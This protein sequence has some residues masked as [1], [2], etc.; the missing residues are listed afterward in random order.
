MSKLILIL[1]HEDDTDIGRRLRIFFIPMKHRF[2]TRTPEDVLSGDVKNALLAF[3]KEADIILPVI[4]A[5]FFAD[6]SIYEIVTECDRSKV[7]CILGK[8][9][10]WQL[11][12]KIKELRFLNKK[13]IV[14][15]T[16]IDKA[17]EEIVRKVYDNLD[18]QPSNL[19]DTIFRYKEKMFNKTESLSAL[20]ITVFIAFIFNLIWALDIASYPIEVVVGTLFLF[21]LS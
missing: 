4:T 3:T 16:F 21:V 8:P 19:P 2:V 18:K 10:S 1:H 17:L 7:L 20:K 13:S 12:A 5:D 9:C 15:Y 6:E 11:D 14:E